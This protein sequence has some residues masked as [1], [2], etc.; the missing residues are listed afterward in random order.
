MYRNEGPG[1][2]YDH[3]CEYVSRRNRHT[4]YIHMLLPEVYKFYT[5]T[6]GTLRDLHRVKT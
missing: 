4:L 2:I 1:I 5:Q 6:E 3:M